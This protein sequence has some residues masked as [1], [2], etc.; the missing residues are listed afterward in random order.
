VGCVGGVGYS[1][2]APNRA[3]QWVD[4]LRLGVIVWPH[5]NLG[6]EIKS[7]DATNQSVR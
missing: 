7:W 5:S 2:I 1:T 6:G 3:M 4:N